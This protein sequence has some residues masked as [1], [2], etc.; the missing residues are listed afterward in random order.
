MFINMSLFF[1]CRLPL[2]VQCRAS[3]NDGKAPEG[4]QP[5]KAFTRITQKQSIIFVTITM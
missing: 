1:C 5:T 2:S 3:K 4:R